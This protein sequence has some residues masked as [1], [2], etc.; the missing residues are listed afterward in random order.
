LLEVNCA[1][2]DTP[3]K[4]TETQQGF[5][6]E[7]HSRGSKIQHSRDCEKRKRSIEGAPRCSTAVAAK[8]VELTEDEV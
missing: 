1:G 3:V 2:R 4:S 6:K 5:Q 8:G 7:E